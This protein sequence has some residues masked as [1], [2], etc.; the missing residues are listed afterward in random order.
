MIEKRR[1]RFLQSLSRNK[2]TA[3]KASGSLAGHVALR[4]A[5]PRR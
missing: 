5:Q 2:T 3:S 4:E 1:S